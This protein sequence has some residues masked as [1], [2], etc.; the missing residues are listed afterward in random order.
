MEDRLAAL[1]ARLAQVLELNKKLHEDLEAVREEARDV[2]RGQD[3]DVPRRATRVDPLG[4]SRSVHSDVEATGLLRTVSGGAAGILFSSP[5]E[6]FTTAPAAPSFSAAPAVPSASAMTG[7]RGGLPGGVGSRFSPLPPI[8]PRVEV[9]LKELPKLGREKGQLPYD[10][11]RVNAMAKLKASRS[12]VVIERP[13]P[14]VPVADREWYMDANNVVYYAIL[15]AVSEVRLL[16][17]KVRRRASRENSARE[18][19]EDIAA[20]FKRKSDNNLQMLRAKLEVLSPGEK[21]SMESFLSRCEDLREEYSAYGETLSDR[22]LSVQVWRGLSIQWKH[23]CRLH[24]PAAINTPWED[25]AAA[26]QDED[27]NRRA[28]NTK[29]SDA[30]LP[31]GWTRGGGTPKPQA[32]G[33]QGEGESSGGAAAVHPKK[34]EGRQHKPRNYNG[35]SDRLPLVCYYCTRTG[36][37]W[38]KCDDPS[39]PASWKPSAE[40]RAKADRLRKE[41]G[42]QGGYKKSNRARGNHNNEKGESSQGGERTEGRVSDPS[43]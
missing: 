39:K 10:K 12:W 26:L 36:H 28:S 29:A 19:W 13:C 5:P 35:T 6:A 23:S 18:A 30:L 41:R 37:M 9:K 8:N 15:E 20:F 40:D 33:A 16:S 17:D 38:G 7:T 25:V 32:R 22:D 34:E 3:R 42:R 4:P 2:P 21:E 11:W 27:N 43:V 24:G 31:L 14:V 1:E